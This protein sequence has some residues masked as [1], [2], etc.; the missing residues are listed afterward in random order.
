MVVLKSGTSADDGAT[1]LSM[2]RGVSPLRI[3]WLRNSAE[4]VRELIAKHLRR[5]VL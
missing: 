4:S 5:I 3:P 2:L 1:V